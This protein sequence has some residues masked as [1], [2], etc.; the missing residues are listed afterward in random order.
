MFDELFVGYYISRQVWQQEVTP[1]RTAD[2][3]ELELYMTGDGESIVDGVHYPHEKGNLL[4]IHPGQTRQSVRAFECYYVHFS[5]ADTAFVEK[6][7]SPLPQIT[8]A[9]D[10]VKF[11]EV[12]SDM[13]RAQAGAQAGAGLYIAGKLLELLSEL[14]Y[15]YRT[16]GESAGQLAPYSLDICQAVEFMKA[17]LSRRLTL[18][19][20]AAA[21]NLSPSYFHTL[22]KQTLGTTPHRYLCNLRLSYA[23]SLLLN[24]TKSIAQIAELCGFETQSYLTYVFQKELHI[25]PKYYREHEMRVIL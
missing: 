8:H 17:N 24:S 23:K 5:C 18:S 20:I 12:F 22:F 21:A 9:V 1:L 25:T 19:D 14:Y 2:C 13:L 4:L 6:Y 10:L 11:C 3:Y 16:Y 15:V 7:L